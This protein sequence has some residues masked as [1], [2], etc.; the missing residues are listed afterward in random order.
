MKSF[1]RKVFSPLL[2]M[3]EH[4]G[5]YNYQPS[6]RKILIIL[7]LLFLCLSVGCI[8]VAPNIMAGLLPILVFAGVGL[9]GLIVGWIGDDSAVAALWRS[10]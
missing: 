5:E 3:F 10:K 7:S 9:T 6:H 1:F 2:A 8:V 4:E